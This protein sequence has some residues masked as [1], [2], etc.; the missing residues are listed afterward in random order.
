MPFSSIDWRTNKWTK[1][2][3]G[4]WVLTTTVL[5][6]IRGYACVYY[7]LRFVSLLITNK[8]TVFGC[9]LLL[10]T[11]FHSFLQSCCYSLSIFHALFWV[12]PF[13]IHFTFSYFV[14]FLLFSLN[15]NIMSFAYIS[16]WIIIYNLYIIT[17]TILLWML[18]ELYSCPWSSSGQ[19]YPSPSE[20]I[21]ESWLL[22]APHEYNSRCCRF[23]CVCICFVFVV[24]GF[25]FFFF[26]FYVVCLF[27]FTT[28]TLSLQ[29]TFCFDLRF[30]FVELCLYRVF[31]FFAYRNGKRKKRVR[32]TRDIQYYSILMIGEIYV[33]RRLT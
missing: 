22:S 9:T 2:T 33:R 1:T 24:V 32:I 18:I 13:F 31:Q 26:I 25:V 8:I 20:F 16:K 3:K 12:Y 15:I 28:H 5:I 11:S 30:Y 19:Q 17:I 29:H 6:I 23:F 10:L 27:A 21:I 4:F 14:F 7:A